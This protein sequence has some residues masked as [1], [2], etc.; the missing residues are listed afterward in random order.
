MT[1]A[2]GGTRRYFKQLSACE[3]CKR[4]YYTFAVH[5]SPGGVNAHTTDE[6]VCIDDTICSPLVNRYPGGFGWNAGPDCH[7]GTGRFCLYRLLG[8]RLQGLPNDSLR[9]I[10]LQDIGR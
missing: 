7:A 3:C 4:D 1:K 8:W 10:G 9:Q 6:H 2:T 5:D